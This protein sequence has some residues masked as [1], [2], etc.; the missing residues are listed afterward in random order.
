MGFGERIT[1]LERTKGMKEWPILQYLLTISAQPARC[2]PSFGHSAIP[3]YVSD[4]SSPRPQLLLYATESTAQD[5]I[6]K[7]NIS[8]VTTDRSASNVPARSAA[9]TDAAAESAAAS[10]DA[11]TE[12]ATFIF[13]KV[14]VTDQEALGA[15]SMRPSKYWRA[16]RQDHCRY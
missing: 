2:S 5:I 12:S 9:S 4:R 11:S 7:V 1:N 6:A 3:A 16:L 8:I 10:I 13:R 15:L 14:A